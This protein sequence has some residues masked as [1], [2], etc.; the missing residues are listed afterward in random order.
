M[1]F[2]RDTVPR[3]GGLRTLESYLERTLERLDDWTREID[4]RISTLE[5]L[6]AIT[7]IQIRYLWDDSSTDM[8]VPVAS[9][10]V[11]ANAA[12]MAN[13]TQFAQSRFDEFGRLAI[14][15]DV[16]NQPLANGIYQLQD[17]NNNETYLYELVAPTEQRATDIV[18]S[19]AVIEA[20]GPNP[21]QGD[22]VESSYWPVQP[23]QGA[24][25]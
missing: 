25:I 17:F 11:K 7:G 3:R 16:F 18:L 21:G 4:D 22:Q 23:S 24:Q 9:G 1:S 5:R 15:D 6:Q 13:A 19:V 20:L 10:F 12:L 8:G 14:T 2:V